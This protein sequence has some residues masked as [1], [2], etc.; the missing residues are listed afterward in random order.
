MPRLTANNY[1]CDENYIYYTGI[2]SGM[3][4]RQPFNSRIWELCQ[5]IETLTWEEVWKINR[6]F[7]QNHKRHTYE[8]K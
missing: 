3:V 1:F 2:A 4:Y 5:T 6:E 8:H 7:I